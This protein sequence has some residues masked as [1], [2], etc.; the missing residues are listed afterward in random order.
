MFIFLSLLMA[1]LPPSLAS[2]Q[3]RV[4]R[5][6]VEHGTCQA[7]D[8][9]FEASRAE[10]KR[11]KGTFSAA[12]IPVVKKRAPGRATQPN[13]KPQGTA[14]KKPP[15]RPSPGASEHEPLLSPDFA[16]LAITN[17]TITP[18]SPRIEKDLITI[19]TTIKNKGVSTP[20]KDAWFQLELT[21]DPYTQYLRKLVVPFTMILPRLDPNSEHVVTKTARIP[22]QFKNSQ[23]QTIIPAPGSYKVLAIVNTT[24]FSLDEE[25]NPSNN[26]LTKTFVVRDPPASDLVLDT[27]TLAPGCRIRIRFHNA[28]AAIPDADFDA[29]WV[30]IQEDD[31]LRQQEKLSDVDDTGRSKT[32]GLSL[33]STP[34]YVTYVWPA[35]NSN[36]A[37][38][39]GLASGQTSRVEVKLDP[40]HA[41]RDEKPDNNNK[42]KI[43][44]CP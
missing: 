32:S 41:I 22:R 17:V 26:R 34:N 6:S 37:L 9:V 43:L 21:D 44:R 27:I 20:Q 12:P 4:K 14:R 24:A 2:G 38:D 19:T 29:A 11:R 33:T 40:Y 16:D 13:P 8:R 31:G 36:A 15:V 25:K 39:I 1:L 18:V 7:G 23:N 5:A 10:C 35:P 3:E 28:G 42:A 30:S